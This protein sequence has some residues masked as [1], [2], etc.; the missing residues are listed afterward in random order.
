MKN[1]L[2]NSLK[3]F[4]VLLLALFVFPASKVSADGSVSAT[5]D[6]LYVVPNDTTTYYITVTSMNPF[7]PANVDT[8]YAMINY[9]GANAG[10][11]RG[12]ITWHKV[13][14]AWPGYQDHVNCTRGGL[15]V[16]DGG[17]AAV[18]PGYGDE[19]I[20]LV[21]CNTVYEVDGSM[22]TTF[23][24]R[25]KPQFADDGP[26][27]NNDISGY[28]EYLINDGSGNHDNTGWVNND[29]NFNLTLPTGEILNDPLDCSIAEG[30]SSCGANIGWELSNP[31]AAP[32][33][34]MGLGGS[35]TTLSS[36]LSATQSGTYAATVPYGNQTFTLYTTYSSYV[37]LDSIAISATFSASLSAW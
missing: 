14:D 35:Y 2:Q 27:T 15:F 20:H 29:V 28:M 12:Y 26:Y 25:F 3:I 11:Y 17:Y 13:D 36:S 33:A 18:Q 19:Y 24:V 23:G 4:A 5:I 32:S 21:S 8:V 1:I 16:S 31:V 30:Q 34:V 9:Q 37:V 22:T 6:S 7:A 10:D